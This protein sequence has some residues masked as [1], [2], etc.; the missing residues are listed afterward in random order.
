MRKKTILTATLLFIATTACQAR[1]LTIA[2]AD[3]IIVILL[4]IIILLLVTGTFGVHYSRIVYRR[5]EQLNRILNALNSTAPS[6]AT[7]TCRST[8]WK[9]S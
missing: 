4:C 3:T 2:E 7:R 6:W 5:N 9:S 1:T 8:N